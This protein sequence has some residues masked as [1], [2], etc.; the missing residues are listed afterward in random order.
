MRK[1]TIEIEA[2]TEGD[3]EDALN[4]VKDAI[5]SGYVMAPW[6]S[7]GEGSGYGFSSEGDFNDAFIHGHDDDDDVTDQPPSARRSMS[8]SRRHTNRPKAENMLLD[9]IVAKICKPITAKTA[10]KP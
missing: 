8:S 2:Q 1:F 9:R 6:N 10:P 7:D 3:A 5:L 4:R